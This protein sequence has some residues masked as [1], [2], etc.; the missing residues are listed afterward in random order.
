MYLNFD[1][2]CFEKY[3]FSYRTSQ[4]NSSFQNV[5]VELQV[6]LYLNFNV[7]V[8]KNAKGEKKRLWSSLRDK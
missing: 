8:L 3:S 4:V 5:D 2:K 1:L 6:P 7:N